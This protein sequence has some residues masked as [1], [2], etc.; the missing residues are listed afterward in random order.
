MSL[1]SIIK[2]WC[3]SIDSKAFEQLFTDGTDR[4]LKA[5]SEVSNDEVGFIS[6]LARIATDLRIDDWTEDTINDFQKTIIRYKNTAEAFS[7]DD[8][9]TEKNA[10]A[11]SYQVTFVSEDGNTVTK[12]FERAEKT[13]RGTLLYN[14]ILSNLDSMG[15]S[16]TEQEKRQIIMD[17][18]NKLC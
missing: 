2:D 13:K 9:V 3:E 18:L 8:S 10:E 5:F 6:N 11:N 4:C 12:R 15:Q 14:Q 1:S 7:S 17:I 16:I